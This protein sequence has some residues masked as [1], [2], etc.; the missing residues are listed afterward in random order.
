M[1]KLKQFWCLVTWCKWS[2]TMVYLRSKDLVRCND[3]HYINK[4]VAPV[5]CVYEHRTVL[6]RE[7]VPVQGGN[8]SLETL[9]FA[10]WSIRVYSDPSLAC[11]KS[12]SPNRWEAGEFWS[13]GWWIIEQRENESSEVPLLFSTPLLSAGGK[14]VERDLPYHNKMH[15]WVENKC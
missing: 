10:C 11:C 7:R 9:Y 13:P 1:L 2:I 12:R 6:L 8:T 5:F 3:E 15:W 14:R 4:W